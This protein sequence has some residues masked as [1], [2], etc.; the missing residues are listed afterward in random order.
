MFFCYDASETVML[1][2]L[3]KKHMPQHKIFSGN[4]LGNIYHLQGCKNLLCIMHD[5]YGNDV[6][7]YTCTNY[8]KIARDGQ[9][10]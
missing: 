5:T 8:L 3:K 9:E 10:I 2:E 7:H 6:V 4:R 1:V